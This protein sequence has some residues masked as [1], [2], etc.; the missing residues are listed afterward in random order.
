MPPPDVSRSSCAPEE[1]VHDQASDVFAAQ[2]DWFRVFC[3]SAL[4]VI[5]WAGGV[6]A[7]VLAYLHI[8]GLVLVVFILTALLFVAL[9][10]IAR[11]R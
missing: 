1:D 5:I 9:R 11:R 3:T 10:L 8:V 2:A 7:A 4:A 6:L